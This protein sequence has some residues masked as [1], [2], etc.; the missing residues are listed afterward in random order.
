MAALD[1]LIFEWSIVKMYLDVII[2]GYCDI[3]RESWGGKIN[4]KF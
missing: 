1:N 4:D 3:I 2:Y